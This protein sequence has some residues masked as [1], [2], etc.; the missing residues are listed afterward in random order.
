MENQRNTLPSE[1]M[2]RDSYQSTQLVE[3]L[4]NSLYSTLLNKHSFYDIVLACIGTDRS[5]GD[6]L[7]P[8]I[9]TKLN[10]L[11]MEGLHVYGTLDQ[12]VHAMNL[13]D[14][15]IA[16]KEEHK[17]PYIIAIDA[18]LGDLKSVGMI[19]LGQGALKPGAGVQKKLP[20][21]GQLHLTGIVNVG[22]F[23]EYFVLQNTRLSV[24]MS[25]AEKIAQAIY[26]ASVKLQQP[27]EPPS[28][29]VVRYHIQSQ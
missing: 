22:G 9:G 23:M 7:G 16:I 26:Q 29:E 13:A 18:C 6:A 17:W 19:T 14:T 25:M 15:V 28:K 5:T 4:S 10:E 11:K 8:L 2:F 27:K 24:V 3:R 20:E 12:P 1:P 21:I